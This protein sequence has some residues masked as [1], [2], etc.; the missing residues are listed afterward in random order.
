ML[1]VSA[2][3]LL[4]SNACMLP[5]LASSTAAR[6]SRAALRELLLCML[7]T[8]APSTATRRSRA[9][10][11]ASNACVLPR[12]A[13]STA[14]RRSRAGPVASNAWCCLDWRHLRQP[15]GH[16]RVPLRAMLVCCLDWRHLRQPGGDEWRQRAQVLRERAAGGA[17]QDDA[18]ERQGREHGHPRQG[19][20]GEKLPRTTP[21][22]RASFCWSRPKYRPKVGGQGGGELAQHV[23]IAS[24]NLA[25]GVRESLAL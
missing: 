20:G 6:S 18:R 10:P 2:S 19:Q 22:A 13:S 3:G 9:G 1:D 5:K 15:G 12:L 25:G 24:L 8:L 16:E 11:V 7:P 4:L 17:A 14:T 23:A 21:V